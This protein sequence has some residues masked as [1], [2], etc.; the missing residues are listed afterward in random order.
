M[1]AINLS[2]GLTMKGFVKLESY[3]PETGKTKLLADWFPNQILLSGM[4]IMSDQSNWID[5]CQV[6]TS[7]VPATPQQSSLQG[8]LAATNTIVPNGT[9]QGAQGAAPYYGWKQRIFEF[10]ARTGSNEILTEVGVGWNGGPA[11]GLISRALI[12][13]ING[14]QISVAWEVGELLLM[15]YELRYYPPLNDVTGDVTLD[16]TVYNYILR[17]AAV[18]DTGPWGLN[19]GN[20]IGQ[21]S[22]STADWAAWGGISPDGDIGEITDP[23]PTS[24]LSAN[25]DNA[26]Q[27]DIDIPTAYSVG[28]G[29]N[30]GSA[31]WNLDDGIRSLVFSTTAGNYQIQFGDAPFADGNSIPKDI[32]F[33]MSFQFDLSWN[34]EE[35]SGQ[36]LRTFTDGT[37]GSGEWTRNTANDRV[38]FSFIAQGAFDIENLILIPDGARIT[39]SDDAD[40]TK[41]VIY[42]KAGA[43]IVGSNWVEYQVTETDSNNGG[44]IQPD[45]CNISVTPL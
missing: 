29:C 22:N 6:G 36:W 7:N 8:F 10:P 12:V 44:P 23:G 25:C 31:G 18:T 2:T 28:M 35:F 34:W 14:Q 9:T 20:Q 5:W 45:L 11:G 43:P 30:C 40:P 26:N 24:G 3:N 13:D 4:A 19:I 27:F 38:R 17:A 16:G 21:I 32:N 1:S 39:I 41:W 15:T 37:T 33:T 42:T